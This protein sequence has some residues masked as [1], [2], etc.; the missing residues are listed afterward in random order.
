MRKIASPLL[1][2]WVRFALVLVPTVLILSFVSYWLGVFMNAYSPSLKF[3]GIF[4]LLIGSSLVFQSMFLPDLKRM[5]RQRARQKRR[6]RG[7]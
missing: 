6:S 7:M 2:L 1:R 3:L 5:A 4:P